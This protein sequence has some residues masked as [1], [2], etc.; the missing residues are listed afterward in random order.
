M[1]RRRSATNTRELVDE[2]VIAI[3]YCPTAQ[4][5]ADILTKPLKRVS[6][7]SLRPWVFG[8][9]ASSKDQT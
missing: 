5:L 9:P 2:G 3:R 1:H 4:E 7:E 8:N 6:F